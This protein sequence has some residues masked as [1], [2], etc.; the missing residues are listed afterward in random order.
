MSQAL[1]PEVLAKSIIEG[2][3]Q[4]EM[5]WQIF[6]IC[7]VISQSL[8]SAISIQCRLTC[9]VPIGSGMRSS[10]MQESIKYARLNIANNSIPPMG[11]EN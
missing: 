5:K 6:F 10:T 3:Y 2:I 4:T 11:I 9:N 7:F 8:R 1:A